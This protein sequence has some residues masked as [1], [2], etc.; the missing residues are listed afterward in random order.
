ML[1]MFPA[2]V[3]MGAPTTVL[4]VA[5]ATAL[6][7]LPNRPSEAQSAIGSRGRIPAGSYSPPQQR[8][9]S[10]RQAH[11]QC[12]SASTFRPCPLPLPLQVVR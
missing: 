8:R 5:A 4:N 7:L 9:E 10:L 3:D 1:V 12:Q 11:V 6:G 2:L